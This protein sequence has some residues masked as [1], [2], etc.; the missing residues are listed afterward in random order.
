[1]I[2]FINV[3]TVQPEKQQ[4]ALCAIQK[5]YTEV[6]KQQDGFIAAQLL[7]SDDG[8]RITAFAHWESEAHL[9]AM[10]TTQAFKELHNQEFYDAI[11]SNDGHVYST[12]INI[13]KLL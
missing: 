12:T 8:S 10:R 5:V 7:K 2:T 11:V 6:V 1:M 4:D 9:Q 3:F 13:E